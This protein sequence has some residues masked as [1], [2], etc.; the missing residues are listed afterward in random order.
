MGGVH[1]YGMTLHEVA[2]HLIK[3]FNVTNAIA[4]DSGGSTSFARDGEFINYPSDQF[5]PFECE[6]P[7]STA[8]CIHDSEDMLDGVMSFVGS[9][10]GYVCAIAVGVLMGAVATMYVAKSRKRAGDL[11]KSLTDDESEDGIS[12]SRGVSGESKEGA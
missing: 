10:G 2:D 4:L 12:L 9:A 5:P 8:L 11:K 3:F 1:S 6:R 7:T